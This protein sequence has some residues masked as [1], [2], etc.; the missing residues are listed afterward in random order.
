[1]KVAIFGGAQ[2]RDFGA[3][4]VLD[5]SWEM[6]G[7]NNV[8]P[9]CVPRWTRWFNLHHYRTLRREWAHGLA[10]ELAW[11][12]LNPRL[13]CYVLESWGRK[14]PCERIFPRKQLAKM[15]RGNYHCGSF[16]WMVAF[17]VLL[18]AEEISLHG[19]GV[20]Y[21]GG[22]PMSAHAC[23]EYW[24]GYA[25]GRGIAVHAHDVNCFYNY[26]IVRDRKAY[27][28]DDWDLVEDRS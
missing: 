1:M 22:E 25:E 17:A 11:A 24:C 3:V 7:L 18:G 21:E 10:N 12:H 2:I 27:G 13:P 14:L 4:A 20:A 8:I 23:L 5:D 19:I 9:A 16:D 15:P 6:W 28:Y 26:R